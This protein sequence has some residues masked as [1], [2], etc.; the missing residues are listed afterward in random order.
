MQ[1]LLLLLGPA[2]YATRI[3]MILG[4]LILLTGGE[5][6]SL[7]RR[8]WLT[9]IFV[10]GAVISFAMQSADGGV[11]SSSASGMKTGGKIIIAGLFVQNLFYGM[12]FVTAIV[13]QQRCSLEEAPLPP[14]YATSVLILIRLVFRVIE[15]VP[16]NAGYLLGHRAFL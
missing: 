13:F 2:L 5:Q 12:L 15:Y 11:M 3:Y 14:Q 4:R 1:T 6:Y 10:T 8:T 9:K 7:V 16:G